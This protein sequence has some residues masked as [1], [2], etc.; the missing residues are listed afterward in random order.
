MSDFKKLRVWA[1]AHALSLNV[2]RL[3]AS[4]RGAQNASLRSQMVRAAMSVSANIVEGREH[5]TD[6]EF[7]RFLGYALASSSELENHLIVA[8]DLGAITHTD[9]S[10]ALKQVIDVRKMLHGLIDKLAPA[11]SER[12][13]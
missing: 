11:K 13:A 8:R 4:I 3:A 12:S 5:K 6:R 7:A 10:S 1:K 9:F 2:H